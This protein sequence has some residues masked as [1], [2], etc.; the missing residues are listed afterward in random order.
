MKILQ[1]RYRTR[2]RRL[3]EEVYYIGGSPTRRANKR[4]RRIGRRVRE[5]TI[6]I[7]RNYM[8]I[9]NPKTALS[10]IRNYIANVKK[11]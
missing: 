7:V 2:I 4:Q 1:I 10:Q 11:R 5:S 6:R 8:P 3:R 9:M